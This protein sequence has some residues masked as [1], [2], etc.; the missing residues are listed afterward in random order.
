MYG[1]AI[2]SKPPILSVI[3]H[4]IYKKEHCPTRKKDI[5]I[6]DEENSILPDWKLIRDQLRTH[7]EV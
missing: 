7:F 4:S 6:L 5:T 3:S 1:N 2:D